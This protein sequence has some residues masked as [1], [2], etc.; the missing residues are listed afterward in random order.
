MSVITQWS[1]IKF[2]KCKEAL[3]EP[4]PANDDESPMVMG[5]CQQTMKM[6]TKNELEP[7]ARY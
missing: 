2:E 6:R 7:E 5:E 1:K 3:L 4:K